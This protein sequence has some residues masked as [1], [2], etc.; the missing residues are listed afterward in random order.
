MIP[1][2]AAPPWT[3]ADAESTRRFLASDTGGRLMAL[4]AYNRP[5][6]GIFSNIE[7]R[8]VKSGIIE[9]YERCL[10]EIQLARQTKQ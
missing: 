10:E 3:A 6:Y 1:Q 7:E 9:G 2:R 4:L 8:A 5:D